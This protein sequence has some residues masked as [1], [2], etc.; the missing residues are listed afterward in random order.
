M[1]V[2]GGVSRCSGTPLL[3]ETT[4]QQLVLE[5]QYGEQ[6]D[7]DSAAELAGNAGRQQ[8]GAKSC[9]KVYRAVQTQ[10]VFL[11]VLLYTQ[12]LPL[13]GRHHPVRDESSARSRPRAAAEGAYG[14]TEP[15]LRSSECDLPPRRAQGLPTELGVREASLARRTRGR[16]RAA[17]A[18]HHTGQT[19]RA[20]L[21][22][23][24][25]VLYYRE[26]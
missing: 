23:A 21:C 14:T 3:R 10:C 11:G 2:R 8:R 6:L 1:R 26:G 22:P 13:S 19:R 7:W 24:F 20:K 12:S 25:Q 4:R 18:S 15:A 17:A 5:L 9:Y 16:V